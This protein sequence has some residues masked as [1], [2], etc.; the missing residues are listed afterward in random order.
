MGEETAS[1][2]TATALAPRDRYASPARQSTEYVAVELQ[3]ALLPATLPVLPQVRL[4]ARYVAAGHDR[5]AGGDFLDAIMLPDGVVALVVGDVV[6]H[7]VAASVAMGQLRAVLSDR[8]VANPD[9]AG[10]LA[11]ADA[12][13]ARTPG[14]RSA[15]L[16]VLALNAATG[17]FRY[18]TCGHPPPLVIAA[19]GGTRFLPTTRGGPL[20]TGSPPMLVPG[21]LRP[22]ELVLLYSDGLMTRP[23]RTAAE[24]MAELAAAAADAAT[25][26]GRASGTTATAPYRVCRLTVERLTE[27][28]H[29]D[30]ISV[31]AAQWLA[32]PTPAL[33][34]E[35]PATLAALT[36]ARRAL[37]RWTQ[38]IGVVADDRAAIQLAIAELILNAV[39]HAYPA[40]GLGTVDLDA[41]LLEGGHVECRLTDHGT[42]RAP[43]SDGDRGRGLMLVEHLIDDV[44]IGHPLQVAGSPRG[45][46][47]TMVTL[48]HRIRLPVVLGAGRAARAE[49]VD[50]QPM[51]IDATTEGGTAR[52]V[53]R[54]ALDVF[55]AEEF[56]R[57]L[58]AVS[59]G[60]TLPLIVDLA[61]ASELASAGVRALFEVRS[62]LAAHR[63]DMTLMAVAGSRVAF[64]LDLIQLAYSSGPLLPG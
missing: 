60:G 44:V 29:H 34:L 7:G 12:F 40:D 36:T 46:R 45:A 21:I 13:A 33:H 2:A 8:L 58:L 55:S 63:Q 57:E 43:G 25:S 20:G 26:R 14:L 18:A 32:E 15:T 64:V 10:A 52:A 4:A 16:A 48:R 61:A 47:G 41:V 24:A 9:L 51:Q 35:L 62:Q 37:T 30:D 50:G 42:W 1:A 5:A 54:G 39:E 23:H 53:V 3:R 49:G 59:A 22:G 6:G 38:E 19:D 31:L 56:T 27:A 28:G 17:T 11:D